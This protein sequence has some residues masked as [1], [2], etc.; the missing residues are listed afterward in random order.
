MNKLHYLHFAWGVDGGGGMV[1][2]GG[3]NVRPFDYF[4]QGG[5]LEILAFE[6]GEE[7]MKLPTSTSVWLDSDTLSLVILES[8]LV[9]D[10]WKYTFITRYF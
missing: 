10:T 8:I 4:E 7:P 6:G 2:P 3:V 5:F 9:S 1:S